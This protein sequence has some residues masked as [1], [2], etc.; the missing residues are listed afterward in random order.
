MLTIGN[1]PFETHLTRQC[2]ESLFWVSTQQTHVHLN[3][4]RPQKYVHRIINCNSLNLLIMLMPIIIKKVVP[5]YIR[6]SSCLK[7]V[8]LSNGT[9]LVKLYKHSWFPYDKSGS[10]NPTSG[11][12][13][14]FTVVG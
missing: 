9:I 11:Q 7:T 10:N 6:C 3:R 4:D 13:G 12:L 5:L 1:M 14:H 2:Y 8:K